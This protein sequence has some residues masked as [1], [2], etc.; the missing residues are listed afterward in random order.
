MN[1]LL[2]YP[3]WPKLDHQTEFHLPPHGPV[4]M[5]AEI[6]GWVLVDFLM[7]IDLDLA[8]FTINTPF[9]HTS[10][11][12]Q[13][14]QDGRILTN[15]LSLYKAGNVVFQQKQ[16]SPSKLQELYHYGWNTFYKGEPQ[17]YKMYKLFKQ[18]LEKKGTLVIS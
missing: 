1:F 11:R 2:L 17:R 5:A 3:K 12:A 9:A 10:I 8:G 4:V 13:Y 16:M 6:P 7:E 18:A 15:D 14:E